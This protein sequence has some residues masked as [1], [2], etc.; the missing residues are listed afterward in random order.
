[1]QLLMLTGMR[2]GELAALEV[3]DVR[4]TQRTG[5]LVIRH[6]KGATAGGWCRS[7]VRRAPRYRNGSP[8][9]ARITAVQA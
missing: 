7:V 6:S 3:Q 9:A 5:E 1:V 8:T 4:L 2:I